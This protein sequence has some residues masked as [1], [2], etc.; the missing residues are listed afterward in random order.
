MLRLRVW[1]G[2]RF[3]GRVRALVRGRV[4][5]RDWVAYRK[6]KGREYVKARGA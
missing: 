4:T 2:F 1:V 3:N 5:L 6:A